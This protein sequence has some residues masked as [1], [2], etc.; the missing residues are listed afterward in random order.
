[1]RVVLQRE[2][3]PVVPFDRASNRLQSGQFTP[4][5]SGNP[6]GRPRGLARAVRELV[7][8][9]GEAIAQ[10]WLDLMDDETARTADRLEASRL[11][12][13]RG[14]GKATLPIA[15]VEPPNEGDHADDAD[16]WPSPQR[17]RELAGIYR[18]FGDTDKALAFEVWA[19][20]ALAAG[21]SEDQPVDRVLA[22]P[23]TVGRVARAL[24]DQTADPGLPDKTVA[25]CVAHTPS[26]GR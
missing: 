10:F 23:P 4:G 14:W 5:T 24:L 11:L 12:A 9:N 16:R 2:R 15:A 21:V 1:M 3:D 25:L 8:E 20:D 18:E 26:P 13:E 17:M 22:P 7:G 6:G 19:D